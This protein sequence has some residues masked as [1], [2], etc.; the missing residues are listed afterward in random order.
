M[1]TSPTCT[2]IVLKNGTALG[3]GHQL[4]QMNEIN[5]LVWPNPTGIGTRA[6]VG[7]SRDDEDREDVRRDQEGAVGRV[8][9]HVGPE[10]A[11]PAQGTDATG[12]NYKPITVKVTPGGK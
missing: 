1:T 12:K 9:L 6:G 7:A 5:K 4:W 2:N 8:E 11:R 10:G 3:H